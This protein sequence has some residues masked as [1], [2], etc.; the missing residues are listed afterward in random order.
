MIYP[1]EVTMPSGAVSLGPDIVCDGF[2]SSAKVRVQTHIHLDHMDSFETSKGNQRIVSSEATRNLLIAEF[3]ADLPYRSNVIPLRHSEP[4]EFDD[5]KVTLMPNGHMLGSVQVTAEL[6]GGMRLGYSGD[7]QWPLEEVIQ[8]DALVV[9]STYG[10]PENIREFSQG[11]CEE[12]FVGLLH[13]LVAV[14]PVIIK[15]HRGTLQRALQLINDE[16]GCPVIGT[17]RLSKELEVYRRFGYTIGPLVID[18]SYEARELAKGE[19]H[20]RVYG[21]GDHAPVDLG[22]AS[23]VVLS[24]Y[25]TRPDSPVVEYSARSF[26][27]AMSNHA[28]FLGTLEYVRATN[29]KF[30]VTDNTRGGKGYKLATEIRQRLGIQARP[31]SS[32]QNREWGG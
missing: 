16:I 15:A 14:G 30:V 21:T 20:V 9:D 12:Q 2:L 3:N 18:S 24:A 11:E 5:T 27:V 10:A 23:K 19:R 6:P 22:S 25:F 1:I 31:S 32:A 28:D 4:F 26:G 8:V 7:F 17:R 13:S 29:A